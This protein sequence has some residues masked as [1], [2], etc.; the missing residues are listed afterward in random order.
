MGAHKMR[1][2]VIAYPDQRKG[3]GSSSTGVYHSSD[4]KGDIGPT[5]V[6]HFY[7]EGLWR[8]TGRQHTRKPLSYLV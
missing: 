2:K 5:V 6:H 8:W 1:A 4:Q 7:E 3:G